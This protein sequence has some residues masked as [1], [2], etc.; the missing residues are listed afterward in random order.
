METTETPSA[1][2]LTDAMKAEAVRSLLEEFDSIF[3]YV[4]CAMPGVCLPDDVKKQAAVT[5]LE[6]GFEMPLPIPDLVI[7]ELGITCTLSFARSPFFV[8]VPWSAV[9]MVR[10]PESGA[11]KAKPVRRLSAVAPDAPFDE[12]LASPANTVQSRP[13]LRLVREGDES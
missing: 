6:I 12:A 7:S 9:G 2:P 8:S 4:L 5:V 13:A 10:V 11:K 1:E 3:V